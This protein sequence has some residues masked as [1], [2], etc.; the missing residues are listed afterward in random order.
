MAKE[1]IDIKSFL[2]KAKDPNAG[3]VQIRKN[4]KDGN[5]KF[6]VKVG[7]HQTY[8]LKV[9]DQFTVQRLE[10]ALQNSAKVEDRSAIQKPKSG[11]LQASKSKVQKPQP[12]PSVSE[13]EEPTTTE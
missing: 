1:I 4:T 2:A 8:T 7:R 10:T 3:P 13:Q 6:R 5:V 11:H 12:T 9:E